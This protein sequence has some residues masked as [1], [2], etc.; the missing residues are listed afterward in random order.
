MPT[1]KD[2]FKR[3]LRS[4]IQAK[5]NHA[6]AERRRDLFKRRVS[7]ART[8]VMNYRDKKIAEAVK[9]FLT[10]IHILEDWKVCAKGGLTPAHFDSKQDQAEMLLISGVYWDL[11]KVYDKMENEMCYKQFLH[12]L[13]KYILFAK[14]MPYENL[15][16][17]TMRKFLSYGGAVHKK[18][19]KEAHKRIAKSKCFVATELIDVI[20]YDSYDFLCRYRD[21]ILKRSATGRFL[22]GFYYKLSPRV[23]NSISRYPQSLRKSL[24]LLLDLFVRLLRVYFNKL[25]IRVGRKI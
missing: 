25:P 6:E 9:N 4:S 12:Y 16:A 10:Y 22:V 19:L 23:A 21:E 1:S 18:E 11:A 20:E 7:V 17:E 13:D 5:I 15:C 3:Q 14:G 8:G 24:G 2:N